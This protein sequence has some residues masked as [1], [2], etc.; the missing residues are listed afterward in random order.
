M[1]QQNAKQVMATATLR[2][3][4]T[5]V[6][7][8]LGVSG[9]GEKREGEPENTVVTPAHSSKRDFLVTE[10]E[11]ETAARQEETC[12]GFRRRTRG[13]DRAGRAEPDEEIGQA[14]QDG[15]PGEAKAPRAM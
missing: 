14:S 10:D 1:V 4:I 12:Q 13:K 3:I 2:N 8:E 7:S 9:R 11:D 15:K 6:E 5:S